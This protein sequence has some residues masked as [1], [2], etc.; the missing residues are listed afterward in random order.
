MTKSESCGSDDNNK[1]R[2]GFFDQLQNEHIEIVQFCRKQPTYSKHF[3]SLMT[4]VE[5]SSI[6]NIIQMTYLISCIV[7]GFFR[8]NLLFSNISYFH[9]FNKFIINKCQIIY[10]VSLISF[11]FGKLFLYQMFIYRLFI[12]FKDS[13]FSYK[14][15]LLI[16]ISIIITILIIT[17]LFLWICFNFNDISITNVEIYNN[18]SNDNNNDIK[19]I[20]I[21]AMNPNKITHLTFTVPLIILC[22]SDVIVSILIHINDVNL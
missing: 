18:H 4:I 7:Y 6:I 10:C 13:V 12:I 21:C 8:S 14:L 5:K 15:K 11:A 17:Y 22:V 2:I 1:Y 20:Q 3:S 19:M 16:F 9:S